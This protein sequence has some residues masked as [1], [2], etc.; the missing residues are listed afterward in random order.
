TYDD[1]GNI[2]SVVHTTAHSRWIR[3]YSYETDRTNRL[4]A[5]TIGNSISEYD[6]DSHGNLTRSPHLPLIAWDSK[7]QLSRTQRRVAR[8]GDAETTYYVYDSTG[9]RV[10]VVTEYADGRTERIYIG[11]FELYRSTRTQSSDNSTTLHVM[12]GSRR[13]ALLESRGA[14]RS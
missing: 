12:L 1:V 7:D 10:R 3:E 8:S 13:I 2:E 14:S 9:Q 11:G 5:T 6:Y 4:V